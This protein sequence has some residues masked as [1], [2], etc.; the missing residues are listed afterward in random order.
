MVLVDDLNGLVHPGHLGVHELPCG[1]GAVL[2]GGGGRGRGRSRS[3]LYAQP[4][5]VGLRL[6]NARR[7]RVTTENVLDEHLLHGLLADEVLPEAA[8]RRHSMAARTA[9]VWSQMSKIER[10]VIEPI[11]LSIYCAVRTTHGN[12]VFCGSKRLLY[13]SMAG[14]VARGLLKHPGM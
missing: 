3:H 7:F 14:P 12:G 8:D 2:G 5:H 13:F 11:N 4:A 10:V 6:G 9:R 1:D